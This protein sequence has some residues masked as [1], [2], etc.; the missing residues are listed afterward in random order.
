MR[1]FGTKLI[2]FNLLQESFKK[3][4]F[5]W[6]RRVK[7]LARKFRG[8]FYSKIT[9]DKSKIIYWFANS[10]CSSQ[11]KNIFNS[12]KLAIAQC[13]SSELIVPE[14]GLK[15]NYA[16]W[17]NVG[18]GRG[19]WELQCEVDFEIE[20]GFCSNLARTSVYKLSLVSKRHFHR[21]IGNSWQSPSKVVVKCRFK[22][23]GLFNIEKAT[24]SMN[25]TVWSVLHAAFYM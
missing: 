25:Y 6:F 13:N 4:A 15:W 5:G 1:K 8:V 20:K 2:G 10:Y 7:I 21:C 14:N 23:E 11:D 24:C 9:A 22:S 17:E 12:E 3:C 18:N 16:R 19:I